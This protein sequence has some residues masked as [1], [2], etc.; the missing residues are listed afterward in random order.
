MD[1]LDRWKSHKRDAFY[2]KAPDHDCIFHQ[3][4]R[5]YGIEKFSINILEECAKENL[6]D[7]E[8]FYIKE[9]KSFTTAHEF[10][11]N[12]TPGGDKA[13]NFSDKEK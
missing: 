8:K 13:F 2:K 5:K 11:Y 9:Y 12:M 7:L 10:G 1:I 4:I 6:N 3:A